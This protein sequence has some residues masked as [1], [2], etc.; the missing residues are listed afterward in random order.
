LAFGARVGSL[1]VTVSAAGA[2]ARELIVNGPQGTQT[3][4]DSG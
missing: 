1:D 2:Q 3:L 4:Q